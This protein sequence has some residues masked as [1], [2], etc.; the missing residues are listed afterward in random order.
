MKQTAFVKQIKSVGSF[1]VI[2]CYVPK[3][4]VLIAHNVK[5]KNSRRF[6]TLNFA[7]RINLIKGL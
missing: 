2:R 1:T 7:N 3:G 6:E 5:Y 4:T